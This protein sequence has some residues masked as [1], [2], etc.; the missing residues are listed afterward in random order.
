MTWV[1]FEDRFPWHRKVRGLSDTA[2]RLHVS[3]VCWSVEH[4]TDGTVLRSQLHLLS[5]VKRPTTA[6]KE[7]TTAGLWDENA[8]RTGWE[9]HDFLT[10]NES[11]SVVLARREA[12]AERK[13]RGRAARPLPAGTAQSPDGVHPESAGSPDGQTVGVQ[14][15]STPESGRTTPT[16]PD[17]TLEQ[18]TTSVVALRGATKRAT[19]IPE[20]WPPDQQTADALA[21]WAREAT[22]GLQN[23]K[24][25]TENWQDWHRAKG[26]TAKDWTASWRTWMRRAQ[27]DAEKHNGATVR[28][29]RSVGRVADGDAILA[30]AFRRGQQPELGA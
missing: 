5:D 26:D 3:A 6:A 8:E 29:L 20:V 7:L 23:L 12:D 4:L 15:E 16:R 28:A 2:F 21:E 30:E 14:V 25:E 22:P 27:K 10:Y 13:R 19:R 11:R 9:L 18:P 1:R 17:P 24:A